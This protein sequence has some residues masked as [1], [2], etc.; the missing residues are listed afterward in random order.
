MTAV[1][2]AEVINRERKAIGRRQLYFAFGLNIR[3]YLPLPDLV[4]KNG[5]SYNTKIDV[6]IVKLDCDVTKLP[7]LSPEQTVKQIGPD[8]LF[9]TIPDVASFFVRNG[10][11][12][13]VIPFKDVEDDLLRVYLMGSVFAALLLQ[14]NLLVIHGCCIKFN[15][16]CFLCAGESGVGKS[17]LA[18]AFSCRGLQVLSDDVTPINHQNYAF[19]GY[20]SIKL[21][22]DTIKNLELDNFEMAPLT[23]GSMKMRVRIDQNFYR[24]A[25]PVKYFFKLKVSERN[26][27]SIKKSTGIRKFEVVNENLYRGFL[28]RV[29]G[30]QQQHL[31]RCGNFC[32]NVNVLE[33]ERPHQ[34]FKVDCLVDQLLSHMKDV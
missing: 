27:L 23:S 7:W 21:Y 12:I 9:V 28:I 22:M 13:E 31:V 26:K 3:S 18:A 15:D 24:E 20:P 30:A 33:V 2:G 32:S 17:S 14:R 5:V 8:C 6:K 11:L 4:T 34:N 1:S 25:L 19:P 10:S 29:M 16:F